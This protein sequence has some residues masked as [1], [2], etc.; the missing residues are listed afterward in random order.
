[1]TT[2]PTYIDQE[3]W[4]TADRRPIQRYILHGG[5]G[6]VVAVLSYGATIQEL[7]VPD[8][9][10]VTANV[11]LGFDNG[12]QYREKHPHFG[13]VIGRYANRIGG[14][15]F[16][17]DG[18]TH[19]LTPNKGTFTAHGGAKPFDL[20]NWQSE[21]VETGNGPG[22]RLTHV[23]PDG[24]EGFPGELT[25]TV[26][27]SLRADRGLQ[28]DYTATTTKPTVV[29]LTNHAYFN[30][31]GD[32]SG[33]A[34]RHLIQLNAN[35]FTPT[36]VDQIPTGEIRPVDGTVFDLREPREV[37]GIVR[38]GNDPQIRIAR[39]LDH[40]FVLRMAGM[41]PEMTPAGKLFDP[42]SGRV[43]EILTTMPGVQVYTGNSLD[44]SLC[45]HGG[46]LYRQTDAVCFETQQFPDAPNKPEFPSAVLRP[47]DA[48]TSTT[49]YRFSTYTPA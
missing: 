11:V 40:N 47:D 42:A 4:G 1:M 13:T 3:V 16:E 35:H 43:M 23:S 5:D 36:G 29:N 37:D 7:H 44:G 10:G 46:R 19:T 14:S 48:F 26:T 21:I 6:L 45:G 25:A 24:D 32:N 18:E 27:Y 15:A 34:A 38:D 49:I 30:L 17:L 41:A 9:N 28:L 39:G 20:Y 2:E 33:T 31:S 22:V 12:G 8:A